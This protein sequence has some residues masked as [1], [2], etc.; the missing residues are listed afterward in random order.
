MSLDVLFFHLN[1]IHSDKDCRLSVYTP[2]A[3]S[4]DVSRPSII[5]KVRRQILGNHL[6]APRVFLVQTEGAS[7]NSAKKAKLLT[8]FKFRH[9]N[10]LRSTL[11]LA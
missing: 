7:A 5:T 9:C 3:T 8:Y 1:A 11:S 2:F 4:G 10:N 6:F